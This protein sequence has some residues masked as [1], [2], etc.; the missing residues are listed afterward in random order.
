MKVFLGLCV[1]A[2]L[3]GASADCGCLK[4]NPNFQVVSPRYSPCKV[5]YRNNNLNL[6]SIAPYK[7]QAAV[8]PPPPVFVPKEYDYKMQFLPYATN[9]YVGSVYE[10]GLQAAVVP[11]PGPLHI[12]LQN[13]RTGVERVVM[14]APANALGCGTSTCHPGFFKKSP[15]PVPLPL[16]LHHHHHHDCGCDS[17]RSDSCGCGSSRR[18]S[19]GYDSYDG[20]SCGCD[21]CG[22]DS[23]NR[24]R[25]TLLKEEDADAGYKGPIIEPLLAPL[26]SRI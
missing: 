6:P 26:C 1:L 11:P 19:Y 4:C 2:I 7:L 13:L 15:L 25:N 20:D 9:P 10:Y 18:D 23:C 5:I 17:C 12:P 14:D 3:A 22:C 24:D 8:P 16:H 21:T